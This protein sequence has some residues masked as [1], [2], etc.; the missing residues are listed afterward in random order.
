MKNINQN[1]FKT[2]VREFRGVALVDFY[3]DWCGPCK[4]LSPLLDEMSKA[5]HD[6]EVKFLK[7]NVDTDPAIPQMLGIMSIPT[8]VIFK[9][10]Q[11]VKQKVGV[12]SKE[13]YVMA[14]GDAKRS[15][16]PV[17][18]K[19]TVF[20]TPTCPYCH[21][22]K[23]Y[24]KEKEVEFEDFDVSA[25]QEKAEQMV[26]RSGQMGVPQLWIGDQVVMG[27]NVPQINMILG[28]R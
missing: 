23:N 26:A 28:I 18:N 20:S 24:L 5:N 16:S 15:E 14:I 17:S 10:G 11:I 19:V 8:V 22:V 25:D 9:D 4:M 21:M 2:E 3:A 1:E 6:P 27:F 7:M 12:A 13:E